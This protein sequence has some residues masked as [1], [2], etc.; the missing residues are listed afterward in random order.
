M[1]EHFG[2]DWAFGIV[3]GIQTVVRRE[4]PRELRQWPL[5][6]TFDFEAFSLGDRWFVVILKDKLAGIPAGNSKLLPFPHIDNPAVPPTGKNITEWHSYLISKFQL[7]NEDA[8]MILPI[9]DSGKHGA[10]ADYELFSA[11]EKLLWDLQLRLILSRLKAGLEAVEPPSPIAPTHITYNVVGTNA[12]VNINSIDSSVNVAN[13]VSRELFEQ[14]IAAIQAS[15]SEASER[16]G[17]EESIDEMRRSYGAPGFAN[18][19]VR[20]MSILAD[21]IGVFGPI[22]APYLP[23][24]ARLLTGSG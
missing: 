3:G 21:H 22:V 11:E 8:A 14:L 10:A 7:R 1:R 6:Q 12:R 18:A 19:Y 17:L 20:F 23:A 15:R 9:H 4:F 24:L 5:L 13:D 16:A 2:V